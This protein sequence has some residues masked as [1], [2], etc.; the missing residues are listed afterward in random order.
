VGPLAAPAA[1]TAERLHKIV[2]KT[3]QRLRRRRISQC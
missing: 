3:Q 1:G 2:A